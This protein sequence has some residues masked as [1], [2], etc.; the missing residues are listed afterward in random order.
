MPS[1]NRFPILPYLDP[2]LDPDHPSNKLPQIKEDPH[3]PYGKRERKR[4]EQEAL[5][6][7]LE[8]YTPPHV[9]RS[10]ETD[11]FRADQRKKILALILHPKAV[12]DTDELRFRNPQ[13]SSLS[14]ALSKALYD[15]TRDEDHTDFRRFAH[16]RLHLGYNRFHASHGEPDFPSEEEDP[17]IP[18]EDICWIMEYT[19]NECNIIRR[20]IANALGIFP[21]AT[22]PDNQ[23]YD[24]DIAWR[25]DRRLYARCRRRNKR[26]IRPS[27]IEIFTSQFQVLP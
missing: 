9:T 19:E 25:Y 1:K 18:P 11:V 16:Q 10:W 2:S 4:L 8:E 5:E 23:F 14:R 20:K 13:D 7:A 3:L 15:P 21:A 12:V 17:A 24:E 6:K 27:H 22:D 26:C